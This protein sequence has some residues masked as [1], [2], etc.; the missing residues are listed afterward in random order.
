MKETRAG[1][2]KRS[3]NESSEDEEDQGDGK[4]SLSCH[5][6]CVSVLNYS[7]NVFSLF[8]IKNAFSDNID[9]LNSFLF[10]FIQLRQ[11]LDK[12][13]KKKKKQKK[14]KKEKRKEKKQ[15]RRSSGPSS[16]EEDRRRCVDG[17]WESV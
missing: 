11:N 5:D 3:S 1:E 4:H 16:D 7:W 6:D 14:E 13:D 8:F 10:S 15:K 9:W 2:E 17:Y 12:K